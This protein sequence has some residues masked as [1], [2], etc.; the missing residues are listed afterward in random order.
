MDGAH[1][2]VALTRARRRARELQVAQAEVSG[3]PEG[4]TV[5]LAPPAARRGAGGASRQALALRAGRTEAAAELERRLAAAGE[6]VAAAEAELRRAE[7]TSLPV[8]DAF[9]AE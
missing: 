8:F 9:D 4:R 2:Q 1:L 7:E 3:L 6:E 5:Y